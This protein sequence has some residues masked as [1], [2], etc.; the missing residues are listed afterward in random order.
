V[1]AE[2]V[3]RAVAAN[4]AENLETASAFPILFLFNSNFFTRIASLTLLRRLR[5]IALNRALCWS[6]ALQKGK[7]EELRY[8]IG[9]EV[10]P[11]VRA[12]PTLFVAFEQGTH[13]VS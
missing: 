8:S 9:L 10:I 2:A 5:R 13:V 7:S 1:T 3:R 6:S 11:D 4:K 12:R